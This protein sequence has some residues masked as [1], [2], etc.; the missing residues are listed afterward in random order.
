MRHNYIFLIYG[1]MT[2]TRLTHL[3]QENVQT[4]FHSKESASSEAEQIIHLKR[5]LVSLKQHYEKSLQEAQIQFQAEQN[6]RLALQK[7]LEIVQNQSAENRRMHEEELLA[8][9]DQHNF[10]KEM[11]TKAQEEVN[12]L[13]NQP[14]STPGV[15]HAEGAPEQNLA[16]NS[17]I[18]SSQRRI[19]LIKD[20]EKHGE[21]LNVAKRKVQKLEIELLE[22]KQ[23]AQAQI[24]QLHQLLEEQKSVGSEIETVV[25]TT[26]SHHLRQELESI[27]R[28]MLLGSH[29][30]KALEVKYIEILN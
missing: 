14:F 28:S 13:R 7:E 5:L 9:R 24:E 26:S 15:L 21:E 1:E 11:L 30:T 17:G 2:L 3:D 16:E 27:K 22:N 12:F 6:Q 29:E 18:F 23:H 8:L 19:D 10:L 4:P 20:N 25:S